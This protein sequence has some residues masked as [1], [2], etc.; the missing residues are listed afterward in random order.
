MVENNGLQDWIFN[1]TILE[2][3]EIVEKNGKRKTVLRRRF[4]SYCF[5]KMIYSD[6]VYFMVTHIHGVTGFVGAGGKPEALTPEEVKRMGL[7]KITAEDLGIQVG[8]QVR[9]ISG[10]FESYYGE[11][12]KID[13]ANGTLEVVLSM[14]GK[15]TPIK[16]EFNQVE[17]A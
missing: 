15:P 7:E 5:I 12:N 1:V 8:D 9:I 3:E 16:L 4:P 13:A 10:A 2:D 11:V 14:F 17:K 6:H